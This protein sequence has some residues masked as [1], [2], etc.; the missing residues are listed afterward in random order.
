MIK[1]SDFGVSKVISNH[2][3]T[4]TVGTAGYLAP[5]V[6]QGEGYEKSVDYWSIWVI[7]YILLCGYPPFDD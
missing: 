7:M 6:L 2:V 1:L 5:E 4:T 3:M